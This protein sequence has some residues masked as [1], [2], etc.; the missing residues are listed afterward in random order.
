MSVD[1]DQ[2]ALRPVEARDEQQQGRLAGS[3]RASDGDD[4]T[5]LDREAG[6][7]QHGLRL[8]HVAQGDALEDDGAL[9]RRRHARLQGG[10]RSSLQSRRSVT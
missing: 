1:P 9:L 4:L 3:L 10:G 8:R 2:S 7:G 5:G 6:A